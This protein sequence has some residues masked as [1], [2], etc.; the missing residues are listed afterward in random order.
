VDRVA[1]D[2]SNGQILMDKVD[3]P[4]YDG[5]SFNQQGGQSNSDVPLIQITKQ[6]NS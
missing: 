4:M 5:S 2:Y 3:I 1:T 6:T